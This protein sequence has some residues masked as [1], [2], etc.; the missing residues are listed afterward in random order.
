MALNPQF[1]EIGKGFVQ[2]YYGMFD[3]V[4]QRSNLVSLYNVSKCD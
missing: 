4:N 3:D 2:A 1:D